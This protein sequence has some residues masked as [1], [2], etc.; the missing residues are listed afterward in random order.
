M[1]LVRLARVP[2]E[3]AKAEMAVGDEGALAEELGKHHRL[4]VVTLGLGGVGRIGAGGDLTEQV[5]TA[6]FVTALTIL[7]DQ[8]QRLYSRCQRVL[9][10]VHEQADAAAGRPVYI[11]SMV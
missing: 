7:P 9:E 5:E 4:A 8:R 6:R 10:P 3:L 2:V 11:R 1:G